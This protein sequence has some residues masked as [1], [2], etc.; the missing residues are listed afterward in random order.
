MIFNEKTVTLKNNTTAILRNPRVEDA[1]ALIDFIKTTSGETEFLLRYPEEWTMTVEQEE[2][3]VKRSVESPF[4]LVITCFIDGEIAGNCEIGFYN[5]KK[6]SHR[7]V[8]AI[9]VLKKYWGIGIGTALMQELIAAAEAHEGT[10]IVELEVIEG[11]E[12]GIRLY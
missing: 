4:N 3:W 1:Q 2:S 10:E 9:S 6:N 7:S 5:G 12:R 8:I 11:N